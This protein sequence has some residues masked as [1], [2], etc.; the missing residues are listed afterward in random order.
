MDLIS[1]EAAIEAIS[2]H[3]DIDNEAY[4][5]VKRILTLQEAIPAV[6]LEPLCRLLHDIVGAPCYTILGKYTCN[7]E[8][9]DEECWKQFLTK[10]MEG[11]DAN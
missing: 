1:R 3:E 6:P 4:K 5:I 11:L 10:W 8:W 7:T 9:S 2:Y